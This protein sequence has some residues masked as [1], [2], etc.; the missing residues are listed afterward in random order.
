LTQ[1]ESLIN[2]HAVVGKRKTYVSAQVDDILLSTG[3]YRPEGQTFRLR[4][5]DLDAHKSWQSAVN[6][7]LPSGSKFFLEM[8]YNGNG[9]IISAVTTSA[10]STQCNPPTA[11]FYDSPGNVDYF[12]KKPLGSGT[13]LWTSD[14]TKYPWSSTCAKLDDLTMWFI[15]NPNTFAH[16]SHTFTHEE[17][18]NA[19]YHDAALEIQFNIDWLKQVGLWTNSLMSQEGLIPPA[20]TGLLNGDAIKAWMDNGIKYVVGDNTRPTLRN[21]VS[22]ASYM[23][24]EILTIPSRTPF[25]H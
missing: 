10:G 12:F 25:M 8:G 20:I 6:S 13:N 9:D 14:W 16:V 17:M 21:A 15:N 11:V 7:R 1:W 19:T 5:S 3:L 23:V 24:M 2:S 18:N 22:V 4:T